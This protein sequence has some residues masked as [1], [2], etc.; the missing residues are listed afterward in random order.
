MT[1]TRSELF[2][3]PARQSQVADIIFERIEW[4]NGLLIESVSEFLLAVGGIFRLH[5]APSFDERER[6]D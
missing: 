5:S 1:K 2:A 6:D 3:L 4:R